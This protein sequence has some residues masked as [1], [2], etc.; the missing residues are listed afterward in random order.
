MFE[1]LVALV[2]LLAG[3]VASVVGFGIGSLLTPTL[4][5]QMDMKLAVA[6]VSVPHL[7]ATAYRLW[8]V[9]GAIDRDV[10]KSFGLTSAV[11][12]L[13]GA[14]LGAIWG[15][16]GLGALLAALLLFVGIGGL[17]GFL[18]RLQFHGK[19]RWGA[20]LASGVFGGL[21]GN[22]GGVRSAALLG[23]DLNKQAFVATA[24]ASGVIVDLARM[25]V[26]GALYWSQL[27]ERWPLIAI[28]TAGCLIGTVVGK[29]TLD[30][31]PQSSFRKVV[32]VVLIATAVFVLARFVLGALP[33]L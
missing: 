6:A 27:A 15:N 7:I 4:A 8:L 20:G 10:F 1:S 28:A 29:R 11:G 21:V 18:D 13:C 16:A 33:A 25:P 5:T 31:V 17:T 12:S 24:T 30:R 23:F 32:C 22:Q 2:A 14:V 26:Y 3:M 9:R 19:A